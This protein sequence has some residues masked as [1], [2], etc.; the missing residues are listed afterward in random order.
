M[1]VSQ[2]DIVENLMIP[3]EEIR[4]LSVDDVI[5]TVAIRF[6]DR[7]SIPVIDKRGTCVG[8]IYA[9]DCN[10]VLTDYFSSSFIQTDCFAFKTV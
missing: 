3:F 2:H 1:Q 6:F 5:G 9:A 8:V 4:P 7:N 10:Q